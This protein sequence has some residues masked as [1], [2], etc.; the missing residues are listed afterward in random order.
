MPCGTACIEPCTRDG[1][2]SGPAPHDLSINL[3]P[4]TQ[5]LQLGDT[6][7]RRRSLSS[8]RPTFGV[9]GIAYS[10]QRTATGGT[11]PYPSTLASGSLPTGLKLSA[12]KGTLTGTPAAAGSWTFSLKV[13][14]SS[15]PTKQTVTASMTMQ[16]Y[17][18]AADGSGTETVSPQTA[19]RGSS[20]NVFVLTYTAPPSGALENGKLR[21]T[22][23]TGW[24]APSTIATSA[25]LVTTSNGAIAASSQTIN[26]SIRVAPGATLTITYGSH[27]ERAAG[28]TV[29]SKAGTYTFTTKECSS[30]NGT[31]TSISGSPTVAVS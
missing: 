31:L 18:R 2:G 10:Y 11:A 24:T 19:T 25:G 22:V 20:G 29:S 14:D 12:T 21:I 4:P 23:P 9:A 8:P 16:I 5:R 26:I 6:H 28:A 3:R 1:R 7:R 27:G 13:T 17:S 30:G 15:N